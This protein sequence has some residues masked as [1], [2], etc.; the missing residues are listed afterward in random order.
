[1]RPHPS[2]VLSAFLFPWLIVFS[3]ITASNAQEKL[4]FRDITAQAGIH[5]THNNGALDRKSVV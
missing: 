5:F 4:H 1:M 2:S 3:L